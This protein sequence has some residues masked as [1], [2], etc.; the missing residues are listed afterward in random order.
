MAA[1]DA[2]TAARPDH[3][4]LY[5]KRS[6]TVRRYRV[7]GRMS[8]TQGR[9]PDRAGDGAIKYSTA[10]VTRADPVTRDL[11]QVDWGDRLD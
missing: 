11:L 3:R 4:V 1:I 9:T 6:P 7:L 5:A 2:S 10:P 8:G